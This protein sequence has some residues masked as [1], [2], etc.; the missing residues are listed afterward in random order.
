M[1][2]LSVDIDLTYMPFEERESS[3][4]NIGE[5][6]ERIKKRIEN[7]IPQVQVLHKESAAKLAVSQHGAEIKLEVNLSARGTIT[8]P[9]K[10]QLCEKAK[11]EFNAFVAMN[12][13][14]LGQLY[15]GKI[16]A[17]LDR[18]HPRDLF[19]IKYLL[20]NEGLSEEIKKGFLLYVLASDRPMHE[21]IAP[22]F[23]DHS[24]ALKNQFEG[25]STEVFTYE[26]FELTRKN[27]VSSIHHSLT[28]QDKEF[29]LSVSDLKPDWSIYDFQKFPAVQWK[30]QNLQK[31]K[32]S[33][34]KKHQSQHEALKQT[35]A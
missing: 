30:M 28:Q 18:Q 34:P 35:L 17:A 8:A 25:M 23:Q 33:N 19:D 5:A 16:C 11:S 14:P 22:N 21:I 2:R 10:M 13:V 6:L 20:E 3:L 31:L 4:K 12:V 24:A 15:G 1:P 32:E 29:L 26:D 9:V 27:L 7:A